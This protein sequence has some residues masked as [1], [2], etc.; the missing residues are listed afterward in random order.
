MR[1]SVAAL[2]T[3]PVSSSTQ[4]QGIMSNTPQK[5]AGCPRFYPTENT[6]GGD[7]ACACGCVSAKGKCETFTCSAFSH[8]ARK[9]SAAHSFPFRGVGGLRRLFLARHYEQHP[10][11]IC[12]VFAYIPAAVSTRR[13]NT[14]VRP[15]PRLCPSRK[16][17]IFARGPRYRPT[18]KIIDFSRGDPDFASLKTIALLSDFCSAGWRLTPL[19]HKDER[20]LCCRTNRIF[21]FR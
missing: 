18:Q 13:K 21:T 12:G 20:V 7:P 9:L 4:P 3:N 2:L 15:A 6:F 14:D 17:Q 1:Y 5:F 8:S 19:F 10:A 16:S 11:K